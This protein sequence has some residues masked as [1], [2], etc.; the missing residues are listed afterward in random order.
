[1]WSARVSLRAEDVE[2]E[3]I[4]D[5]EVRA[6]EILDAEG[7]STLTSVGLTI[8]R[9]T[10]N[11]GLLPSRG[12]TTTV[13]WES[14]GVLGGDTFQRFTLGFDYYKT[15]GEDLLDRKTIFAIHS[16]AGYITGN[17][18]FYERFYGG[19]I[20]SLRGFSYRGV[21]PRSG[22]EDDRI[23]GDFMAVAS[24]EVSFPLYG[25]NLRGVVFTDI[26]TV[27]PTV[28]FGTI[29]SSVGAG[30][31]LTLPFLGQAPIAVDFAIPL[32]KSSEDDTQ[33]VSFSLGFQQ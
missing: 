5:K 31:R 10:T 6:Q 16:D 9:D 4:N 33:I 24:A 3:D 32:S 18:P 12:T 14:F 26:G 20:G 11:R 1:V 13:G 25:E 2:I 15:L 27:E 30:F 28:E 29:R 23:G 19:G 8:R 17:D 7:H 21:S 22:P